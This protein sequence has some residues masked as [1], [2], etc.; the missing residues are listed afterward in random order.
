MA[1]L[2]Y[3]IIKLDFEIEGYL[4]N[5]GKEV[6]EDF[7]GYEPEGFEDLDYFDED[8]STLE[9]Q[10]YSKWSYPKEFLT[11]MSKKHKMHIIGVS[12]EFGCDYVEAF[13]IKRETYE[14]TG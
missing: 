6:Y 7:E 8:Q 5:K 10:F 13:E 9:V 3:N 4:K 11:E 12:Y 2:A 14:V 1:N